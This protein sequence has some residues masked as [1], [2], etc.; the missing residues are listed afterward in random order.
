LFVLGVAENA[1][2]NDACMGTSCA[3]TVGGRMAKVTAASA[4]DP[5]SFVMIEKPSDYIPGMP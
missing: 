1:T 5:R 2:V 3:S 4:I